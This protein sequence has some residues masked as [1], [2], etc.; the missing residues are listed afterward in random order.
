VCGLWSHPLVSYKPYCCS[1]LTVVTVNSLSRN[2][3]GIIIG[4]TV[5]VMVLKVKDI[6][7]HYFGRHR[8][9]VTRDCQTSKGNTVYVPQYLIDPRQQQGVTCNIGL[10]VLLELATRDTLRAR[11]SKTSL[12][13]ECWEKFVLSLSNPFRMESVDH[14]GV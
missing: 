2:L 14:G 3:H 13:E 1:T 11:N 9:V 5:I 4:F 7:I 6:V 12:F 10:P 8:V